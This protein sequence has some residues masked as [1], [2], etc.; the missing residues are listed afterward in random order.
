MTQ[1]T[2]KT[3]RWPTDIYEPIFR[4]YDIRGV[5]PDQLNEP[6][7][8][9]IGRV[10][11]T[12]A[13]TLDE[14]HMFVGYD[15]RHSSPQLALAMTDG[16]MDSGQNVTSIGS[17][18]SP[19]LYFSTH[20]LQ[21]T[22][23]SG[24]MITGSH[25]PKHHNGL[26]MVL[27]GN[28]LLAEQVKGLL[29]MIRDKTIISGQASF[30]QTCVIEPYIQK[31]TSLCPLN[32]PIK[33]VID[34]GS[35]IAGK[36]AP[37]L[38]RAIGCEVIELFCEVDGNFPHHHPDPSVAANLHACIAAV[39]KHE[40]DIGLAFDGDADR[41]GVVTNQ[42]DIIWPDRQMMCF[43]QDTLK[44]HPGSPIVFDVKC[45]NNLGKFIASQGGKP[46]LWKTGHS[47]IKAKMKATNAPLAGEMSG[48]LFFGSPWYGFD[49]GL[50]AG[51]K[52]VS[53]LSQQ[54]LDI[55]TWFLQ[56]P[57]SCNTPEL[58]VPMADERK[59]EF[60]QTLAKQAKFKHASINHIDGLRI[61][62]DDGWTLIRASNT[63][64]CLTLRF[65]GDSLA[66]IK[67][68][69]AQIKQQLWKLEPNLNIPF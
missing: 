52:L 68:M 45:S 29:Q 61:E 62:F 11:G 39:K 53:L 26:K 14:Q 46:I 40:A 5:Y 42:G 31:I 60:M 69:Q 17:V 34:C 6:I 27:K 67:R 49:D 19:V 2:I 59:F 37:K 18:P 55:H 16:L 36:I 33:V 21:K 57:N 7:A 65:E 47:L 66:V 35:G 15:G 51:A 1:S 28:T 24:V 38:Y 44:H 23:A 58:Q 63:T 32:R 4:A 41:L 10:L 64:E 54:P 43:A 48:H 30:Q 9:A 25:N 20:Y 50:Y 56:Y 8:Y 12:Y 3:Y 22:P 13:Q